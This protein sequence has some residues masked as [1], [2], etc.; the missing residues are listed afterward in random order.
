MTLPC[1]N[2]FD[3]D[4]QASLSGLHHGLR[5]FSKRAE[6]TG[7][8]VVNGRPNNVK[9]A[10]CATQ[11]HDDKK[12]QI[13]ALT[14]R[15]FDTHSRKKAEVMLDCGQALTRERRW[16]AKWVPSPAD[17]SAFSMACL[18]EWIRTPEDHPSSLAPQFFFQSITTKHD[19]T[20]CSATT[21][22]DQLSTCGMHRRPDI[23]G[24][25]S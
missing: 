21:L 5:D 18:Q 23:P 20:P 2:A 6:T 4:P 10:V 17:H 3:D 7:R 15:L 16:R 14:I 8:C 9:E 25:H 19:P 1:G 12:D 11:Q 13:E 22:V 24:K